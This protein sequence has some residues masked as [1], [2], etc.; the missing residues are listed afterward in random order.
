MASVFRSLVFI[1]EGLK[2]RDTSLTKESTETNQH[3]IDD[4][5]SKF[6]LEQKKFDLKW[7]RQAMQGEIECQRPEPLPANR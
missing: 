4:A 5:M 2:W 1:V 6:E 3:C 7:A